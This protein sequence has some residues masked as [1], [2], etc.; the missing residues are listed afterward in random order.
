MCIVLLFIFYIIINYCVG[1]NAVIK[2]SKVFKSLKKKMCVDSF[3]SIFIKQHKVKKYIL[4]ILIRLNTNYQ[5]L[6]ING[7]QRVCIF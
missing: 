2:Y 6:I 3:T 7:K 5:R 4:I 1:C